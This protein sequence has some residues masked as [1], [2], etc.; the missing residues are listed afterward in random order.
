MYTCTQT[1]HILS[2]KTLVC[3]IPGCVVDRVNI[4]TPNQCYIPHATSFGG[5]VQKSY[6]KERKF[7]QNAHTLTDSSAN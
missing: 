5:C 4:Y 6:D 3:N 2:N 7:L 1:I